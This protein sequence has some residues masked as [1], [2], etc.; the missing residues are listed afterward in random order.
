MVLVL[1]NALLERESLFVYMHIED[2]M[3]RKAFSL[4]PDFNPMPHETLCDALMVAPDEIMGPILVK[5]TPDA[6]VPTT[7]DTDSMEYMLALKVN[8]HTVTGNYEC[9]RKKYKH[10]GKVEGSLLPSPNIADANKLSLHMENA[11]PQANAS[12]TDTNAWRRRGLAEVQLENARQEAPALLSNEH[13]KYGWSAVMRS[14]RFEPEPPALTATMK[15]K[16]ESGTFDY[17]FTGLHIADK[18]AGRIKVRRGKEEICNGVFIGTLDTGKPPP[19]HQPMLGPDGL[20]VPHV[21]PGHE[22]PPPHRPPRRVIRP[23]KKGV[24]R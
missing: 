17:T 8:G 20:P 3:A 19:P 15:A 4:A 7:N 13:R 14:L 12:L 24:R 23:P 11:L 16:F 5:W 10:K 18:M 1:S 22:H 6:W 21:P 9:I 2:R